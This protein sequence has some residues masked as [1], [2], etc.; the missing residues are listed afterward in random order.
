M[1]KQTQESH[2]NVFGR[3]VKPQGASTLPAAK[4]SKKANVPFPKT[5]GKYCNFPLRKGTS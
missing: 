1:S 4:V 5:G 3:T 2:T